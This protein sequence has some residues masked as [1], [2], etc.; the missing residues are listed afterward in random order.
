MSRPAGGHV[1]AQDLVERALEAARG[2]CVV[3]V[4]EQSQAEIRFANNTV[5]TNGTRR[6]R[7]VSVVAIA[8]GSGG[9]S[10]GICSRSGV[11][12]VADM[13]AQ[14]EADADG[15]PPA[16]D[17][18]ALLSPGQA[19]TGSDF[20]L[21]PPLTGLSGLGGVPGALGGAF[22]RASSAGHRL[23]GFV[24]HELA[25]DYVG[26]TTG[27]RLRHAQPTGKVELVARSDD[28][29]RSSWVGAGAADLGTVDLE[30]LEERLTERLGWASRHRELEAGRYEVVLPPDAV[31]D[32]MVL[33]A[34]ALSGREAE[35]GRSVFA[36]AGGRTRVGEQLAELPFRFSS[37]PAA[38][39]LECSPFL[40]TTASN[41]D[42]SVFDNGLPVGRTDW[43]EG[44]RLERLLYHR[45]GAA[46]SG[47]QPTPPG[48]NLLL[49]L[50]GAEGSLSEL[51]GHVERGLLLTCLW[52]IREVDPST[53]LLT[54]LTRDGV[55]L[56]EKG[57][58]AGAVNNFRFNESPIDVLGR[59][60]EAGRTERALSREWNEWYNRT[61]MPALRVADFNMSSVSPAT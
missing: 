7:R 22:A 8:S 23:A 38:P 34:D 49:G 36:A 50:P 37:D 10:V 39:G 42:V 12:D 13:V 6:D 43:V 2:E 15:A 53:L 56:V 21:P 5:T 26:T 25:T 29:T 3:V 45:A 54:G 33:A 44:G 30:A 16:E 4:Q 24:E 35:E 52:Y 19:G 59:T 47:T 20:S 31:A 40:V 55:F 60:I 51:V 11:V 18:S 41:Q 57:E 32:L 58:I 17:A 1:P 61:A 48:D 14:A 27:L 46:R 9:P 28:G